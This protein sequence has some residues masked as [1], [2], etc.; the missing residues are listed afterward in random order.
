MIVHSFLWKFA[1]IYRKNPTSLSNEKVS[2][3]SRK[4]T[5][6]HSEE[7]KFKVMYI[8]VMLAFADASARLHAQNVLLLILNS[9]YSSIYSLMS[10]SPEICHVLPHSAVL[11]PEIRLCKC[12]LLII[13]IQMFIVLEQKNNSIKTDA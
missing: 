3:H 11:P 5:I 6:R 13:G 1:K 10:S 12:S 7:Q 4:Q 8:S 9:I 2:K